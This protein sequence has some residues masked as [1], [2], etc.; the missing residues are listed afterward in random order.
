MSTVKA[1]N[2][3]NEAGTKSVGADYVV[4]GSA[5]A[6]S[7]T[8]AFGTTIN[9][10]FNVSSLTDLGTGQQTINLTNNM[11]NANYSVSATL[12]D[13]AVSGHW[14]TGKAAGSYST[15]AWTGSAYVDASTQTKAHGDL[16]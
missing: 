12:H 8:D 1:A 2:Y 11:A 13:S 6:W 9:D 5:K 16:A 7:F 14:T 10:S 3:A 15:S 4:D